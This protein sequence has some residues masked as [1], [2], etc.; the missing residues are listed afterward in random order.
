MRVTSNYSCW[1]AWIDAAVALLFAFLCAWSI[2]VAN[3]AAAEAVRLYGRN[4][5]SGAMLYAAAVIYMAPA[6]LGFGLASLSMFLAFRFRWVVQGLAV[7]LAAVPVLF[8]AA[9]ALL[10]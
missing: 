5:D 1:F 4:V 7:A 3:A 2:Y 6:A 10:K 8:L 9:D